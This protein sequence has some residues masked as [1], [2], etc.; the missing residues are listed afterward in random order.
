MRVVLIMLALLI[1]LFGFIYTQTS[2]WEGTDGRALQ[3]ISEL[4]GNG[5]TPWNSSPW[6]PGLE[7][8]IL[9]FALG[10][11]VSCLMVYVQRRR[12]DRKADREM[13]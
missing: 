12:E 1:A 8:R 3:V 4:T 2:P 13:E 11:A 9:L 10:T 5:F 6:Q 7:E